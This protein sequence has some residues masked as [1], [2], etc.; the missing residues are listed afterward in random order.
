MKII[1]RTSSSDENFNG[2]CDY[3]VL[4]LTQELAATI[5]QY[6]G[7]YRLL[8]TQIAA[9]VEDPHFLNSLEFFSCDVEFFSWSQF[10]EAGLDPDDFHDCHEI[11]DSFNP[12]P[13]RTDLAR[14]YVQD[15]LVYWES[16]VKHT[17]VRIE[18]AG[19]SMCELA[20]FAEYGELPPEDSEVPT[21]TTPREEPEEEDPLDLENLDL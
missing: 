17:N 20:H 2:E 9:E 21:T 13:R 11:P 15:T 19:V 10:E 5:L 4:T 7:V 18:T 14:M 1:L 8:K 3:A 12:E 16:F 6:A